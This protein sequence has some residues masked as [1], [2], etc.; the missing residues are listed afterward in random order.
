MSTVSVT[1]LHMLQVGIHA[2]TVGTK[3]NV[4]ERTAVE[5]I[6]FP[7]IH[8]GFACP[9]HEGRSSYRENHALSEIH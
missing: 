5:Y 9:L 6:C 8:H 2:T 1:Y 4:C 7:T 3:I